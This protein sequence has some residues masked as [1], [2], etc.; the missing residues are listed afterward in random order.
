M[1]LRLLLMGTGAF[2]LPTFRAAFGSGHEVVGICTQPERTGRGH[3]RH[4]NPVAELGRERG[5]P[6]LQPESVNTAE[7]VAALESLAAD[8]TVVAAYGQ[9]LKPAVLTAARLGAINLHGS[10]LPKYRGAA[11]VQYAVWKGERETGITIFQIEP[12]L[13]AGPILGVVRTPIGAKETSGELMDRLAELAIPLTLDVVDALAA[14]RAEPLVQDGTAVTRAPQLQKSDGLIDWSETS[15]E[16]DCRI[17]AM[18]PWPKPTTFVSRA[19]TKPRRLLVLDV[20]PVEAAPPPGTSAGTV[21]RAEGDEFHVRT[22][23][24]VVALRR[25]QPE[26]K[27]AMDAAEFLR[28]TGVAVGDQLTSESDL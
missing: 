27:R 12:K 20:D 2:A 22:G 1:S 25:I 21:L 11:P 28:G 14:G 17:R 19:G 16:I 24:G 8:L 15:R 18:Q 6:V 10:L 7:S 23:D 4:V 9:I 13:D 26:G 5:V 3:H